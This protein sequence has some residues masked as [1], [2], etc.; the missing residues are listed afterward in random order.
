MYACPFLHTQYTLSFSASS[1]FLPFP[2]RAVGSAKGLTRS[3]QLALTLGSMPGCPLDQSKDQGPL[4]RAVHTGKPMFPSSC[5][6]ARQGP[7]CAPAGGVPSDLC[8]ALG[9]PLT[10]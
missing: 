5:P 1:P 8:R 2:A 9:N 6:A 7:G 4:I 3:G 10:S